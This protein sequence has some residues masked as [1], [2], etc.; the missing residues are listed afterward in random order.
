[1]LTLI[2]VKQNKED[3][4]EKEEPKMNGNRLQPAE[5]R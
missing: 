5:E 1:V 3:T 2:H 4:N